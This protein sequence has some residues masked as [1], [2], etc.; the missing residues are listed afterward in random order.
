MRE[1]LVKT[2][3]FSA[4]RFEREYLEAFASQHNIEFAW[5]DVLLDRATVS[6]ARGFD[7]VSLFANDRA[8]EEVVEALSRFGVRLIARRGA[9][10]NNIDLAACAR[11]GLRVVYVP[12]YSPYSV[13]EH[14]WGLILCLNRKIHRAFNRVREGNFSLD[15]LAGFDVHGKTIGIVG[16]GRIGGCVAQIACGFGCR[17][18][19]S[20]PAPDSKLERLGKYCDLSQLLEESD[21]VTLHCPLTDATRHLID[22]DALERLKPGAMLVNTSRG[23]LVDTGAVIAHLKS[24]RLGGLAIDVYEEEAGL[25]FHDHSLQPITDDVFARLLTF[26]NVLVTGHQAFLTREAL[27]EIARTTIENIAAFAAGRPLANEAVAA[28]GGPQRCR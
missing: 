10:I 18:L 11:H 24:G 7:V 17:V 5:F 3:V 16:A 20:D 6:L 25:F 15:G 22:A 2:A 14:T 21:I 13:A 8:D 19:M 26:P 12:N 23:A 4:H 27:D 1:A 28:R 9:G